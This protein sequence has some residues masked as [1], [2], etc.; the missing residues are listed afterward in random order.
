[1]QTMRKETVGNNPF[2]PVSAFNPWGVGCLSESLLW[3]LDWQTCARSWG[4]TGCSGKEVRMGTLGLFV[5]SKDWNVS[6]NSKINCDFRKFEIKTENVQRHS[7]SQSGSI[8]GERNTVSCWADLDDHSLINAHIITQW[9]PALAVQL[10]HLFKLQ[11]WVME[12]RTT[13]PTVSLPL[14]LNVSSLYWFY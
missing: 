7:V 10:P 9:V 5:N 1:M 14:V 2:S 13:A 4:N 8:C 11:N 12:L 6:I 3:F